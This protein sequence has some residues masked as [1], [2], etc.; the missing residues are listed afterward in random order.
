MRGDCGHSHRSR[1]GAVPSVF[2]CFAFCAVLCCTVLRVLC[3]SCRSSVSWL[4]RLP[5]L[6]NCT[7]LLGP[8]SGSV[9]IEHATDCV[10]VL[11]SRQL[12]IHTTVRSDF[13]VHTRS[14]PIIEHC[15]Q[16]RFAPYNLQYPQLHQHLVRAELATA[17][18][19]ASA[20]VAPS[21]PS[22][23]APITAV[24][25]KYADV[26]D[27]NWL[28]EGAASPNWSLLPAGQG[29]S[30]TVPVRSQP[31]AAAPRAATSDSASNSAARAAAAGA[32]AAAK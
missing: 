3:S 12:R 5:P 10:F 24:P 6:Q 27:F 19:T 25:N 8:V 18:A 13:Y 21:D 23:P 26:K 1:Q 32:S 16:L 17:T 4:R 28:K 29:L 20:A 15:S 30:V 11:A 14:G 31:S 2:W 9:H 22:A 7:F